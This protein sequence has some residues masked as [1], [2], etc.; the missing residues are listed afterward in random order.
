MDTTPASDATGSDDDFARVKALFQ[1][2]CDLEDADAVRAH[3]AALGTA[4]GVARSVFALWQEDAT[5][6]TR[7]AAPV[8]SMLAGATGPELAVG[9]TLG[10]WKLVA[11]LG[12]G[13]MGS[14]F[15]AER[16]DGHYQQRAAVKLLRGWTGA[17]ALA[18]LAHERQVLAS[19]SHPHIARLIDGGATPAGRPYLVM[20]FVQGQALDAYCRQHGLGLGAT[21]ALFGMVCDA[22]AYAHCQ[23]VVHNDIKPAN[24][25]VGED[26][27][28]MLLDFGIAH[29]QGRADPTP[30]A[31]TPRYASPEQ[32]AG[33]APGVPGD[34]YSLGRVLGELLAAL[35]PAA[36]RSS[37]WQAIVAR[38]CAEQPGQRYA[39]VEALQADLRRFHLHLPLHARERAPGYV[40][41]KLV[42][43]RW[44]WVLAGAGALGLSA[45]FTLRLVQERDRAVLAE[46]MA[47][48]EAA[49][50]RQVSEFMV[51][52]F[53][54]ADPARSGKPDISAV[55]LVD[56]GHARLST[57][58]KDQPGLLATMQ[59][60]LGRVYDHMG[61]Q[62]AA[63]SLYAQAAELEG[64]LGRP[65]REAHAL[66]QWASALIDAGEPAK[67][68]VPARRAL[69][70][71]EQGGADDLLRADAL[72]TLGS[73]QGAVG[74][75]AQG[76]AHL[77]AALHLRQA[78][79]GPDNAAVAAS[80]HLLGTLERR[81]GEFAA[82]LPLLE[83]ALAMRKR[84]LGATEL[85]TL[86]TQQLL[87]TTL[88]QMNRIDEAEALLRDLVAQRLAV[89]GPDSVPVGVAL[90]ELGSMLQDAGRMK[91]AVSAY[92][93]ALAVFDRV[94]GR[95]SM[96]AALTLNN[97]AGALEEAGDPGA[98]E[99]AYRES[100][101][102]R[103]ALLAPGDLAVARSQHNLGRALLRQGRPQE[104]GALLEA[105][106]AVRQARLPA[107]N[108]EIIN[109]QIAL[110]EAHLLRHDP[111]PA[112]KLLDDAA[113]H[114]ADLQPLR[115]A[116]LLRARALM[117]ESQQRWPQALEERE[118]GLALALANTTQHHP[119]LLRL[120]L[121]L[122]QLQWRLRR[123]AAVREQLQAMVPLV[124]ALPP[125][126]PLRME[127]QALAR[128]LPRAPAAPP[129]KPA[130]A[131]GS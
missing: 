31:L 6:R 129:D 59:D 15:L 48:Q 104:A 58:L 88:A 108:D 114:E 82:A 97:L 68:L 119:S 106:L 76:Q 90:N 47:R 96:R 40:L 4:P 42:R 57:E 51:G 84:W 33:A 118:R 62:R 34:I 2:V 63:V 103:Q 112:H 101:A 28:A 29:L 131:P 49:T 38:A 128:S 16:S 72:S 12:Q 126:A 87:G 124:E 8:A 69:L 14:V 89:L 130:L 53:E 120:R 67:A 78:R 20:E 66:R 10:A 3:L 73:A 77:Q 13:G 117:L 95:Q 113:P 46:A 123:D 70:L 21:L 75:Y 37:E 94:V 121:E 22:V 1:V 11:E 98:A 18:Q 9:D 24:V 7:F 105:A 79:L 125:S 64:R 80:L 81:R 102:I 127:A 50:T 17:A 92:R 61:K 26:G 74:E 71:R 115:R 60:V 107:G 19:L 27:R 44:P 30:L 45:A 56:R 110:A 122:A 41:A 35:G 55:H 25:L 99:A 23:L 91:R 32:R 5:H 83:Q 85:R 39:S 111:K 100:L 52:L 116:A 109:S 86:D 43:R 93:E 36:G 65:E 54:G